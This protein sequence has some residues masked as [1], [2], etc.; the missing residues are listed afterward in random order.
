[1]T[2]PRSRNHGAARR[3]SAP[4]AA[5]TLL[6]LA[7]A[8]SCALTKKNGAGPPAPGAAG[9]ALREQALDA[10]PWGQEY[11]AW[12]RRS[13]V[14]AG[15]MPPGQI[16]RQGKRQRVVARK[17]PGPWGNPV[18]PAAGLPGSWYDEIGELFTDDRE[19]ALAYSA[20]RGKRWYMIVGTHAWGP[21][22]DRPAITFDPV[23]SPDNRRIAYWA[24]DNGWVIPVIDGLDGIRYNWGGYS[25][26]EFDFSPDSRRVTYQVPERGS[27][28]SRYVID[29]TAQPAYQRIHRL[30]FSPE[31]GHWA[32]VA[33][34]DTG[35]WAVIRDGQPGRCYDAIGTGER[36]QPAAMPLAPEL[37]F[38]ADGAHLAYAALDRGQ[39]VVVVDGREVGRH[40]GPIAELAM[41][42]ET[43]AIAYRARQGA[44]EVIVA[45]D[46]V[47]DVPPGYRRHSLCLSPDGRHVCLVAGRDGFEA[48]Y[49]DGKPGRGYPLIQP[50]GRGYIF[51]HAGDACHY[52]VRTGAT[53]AAFVVEERGLLRS[54]T[55]AAPEGAAGVTLPAQLQWVDEAGGE[56]LFTGA[57]LRTFDWEQQ[58]FRMSDGASRALQ[59]LPRRQHRYF[60]LKDADGIIY[61]GT[62]YSPISSIGFDGPAI[63]VDLF[64]E[65]EAVRPPS[66]RIQAWYVGSAARDEDRR[67]N[68]RLR[69]AL[70]TAGV[71]VNAR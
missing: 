14:S 40:D 69:R 39:G 25:S 27:K 35:Q 59:A 42:K 49:I 2:T 46:A 37:L 8:A 38:S 41:A 20:R 5:G 31:G 26:H 44:R 43:G 63:Q 36:A 17:R 24:Y 50:I 67:F 66:Y 32:Y 64:A 23:F 3:L 1:M 60:L 12:L 65:G 53:H 68:P 4:A 11:L 54:E 52:F 30:T 6:C 15:P 19:T 71:L 57:D 22:T 18:V 13:M 70:E 34:N 48:V 16:E 45:G 21:Y 7:L 61:R 51:F 10:S 29:G 28:R 58:E 33:Q 55:P 56:V 47:T 62:F 9:S